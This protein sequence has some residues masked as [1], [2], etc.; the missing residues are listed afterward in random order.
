MTFSEACDLAARIREHYRRL[1]V[2]AVGRFVPVAELDRE[3]E[4]WGVSVRID[5]GPETA[6]FWSSDAA[7]HYADATPAR[8]RSSKTT[9]RPAIEQ[10]GADLLF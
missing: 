5:G 7:M 2:L 9:R 4:R 1:D 3:P 10:T 8:K 6:R